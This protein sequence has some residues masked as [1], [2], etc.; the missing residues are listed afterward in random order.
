MEKAD[1][2][3]LVLDKVRR[4]WSG[5]RNLWTV[6][7]SSIPSSRLRPALDQIAQQRAHDGRVLRRPFAQAQH[8]FAPVAA[9]AQCY[10]HLAILERCAI[11]Q[12]R[13]EPHLPERP[14]HQFLHLLPA[15]LDEILAHR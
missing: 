13:A 9:D 7:V 15:G 4:S 10:D 3:T 5:T 6:S 1:S 8:R 12:H 11:D 14:L 2:I